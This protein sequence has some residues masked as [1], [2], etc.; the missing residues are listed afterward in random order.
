M[1]E[2]FGE[3]FSYNAPPPLS[4]RESMQRLVGYY[5]ARNPSALAVNVPLSCGN[6]KA[7]LAAFWR[8]N[9]KRKRPIE[10]CEIAMFS[11]SVDKCFADS[12]LLD[13]IRSLRE[14]KLKLEE[15][16]RY[17]EPELGSSDD[18]FG[19]FRSWDYAASSNDSYH[20]LCARLDRRYRRLHESGK[21][22]LIRE[23]GMADRC[24]LAVPAGLIGPDDAPRGWG[25]MY[26]QPG[27]EVL[28]VK[29]ADAVP[30]VSFENRSLLAE[31]MAMAAVSEIAFY[32][33]VERR[34]DKS[35]QYR[36]LPRKRSRLS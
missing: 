11:D 34:P 26:L 32:F 8:N 15:E 6:L 24:Y 12:S 3:L 20:K 9:R 5:C 4:Y 1:D 31:N 28:L 17:C 29:P 35:A 18:L 10:Q 30:G 14:K 33:G 25:L 21:L 27:M 23:S 19:E 7:H 13:E 22:E 16:I 36:R 2:Q